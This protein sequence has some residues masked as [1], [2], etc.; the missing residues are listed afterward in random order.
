MNMTVGQCPLLYKVF[1]ISFYELV[2]TRFW[3]I[4]FVAVSAQKW[5]VALE[6]WKIRNTALSTSLFEGGG[7]STNHISV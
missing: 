3:Y 5:G 7:Y 4:N 2:L 1:I 6:F